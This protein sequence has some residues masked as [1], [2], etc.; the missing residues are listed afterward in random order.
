MYRVSKEIE[1]SAAHAIR[2]HLGG[3]ENMHGHNWRVRAT[4]EATKLD[5]MEMV[6]DYKELKGILKSIAE[7]LD[8]K[9]INEI[10]PFIKKNPTSE[11]I[12]RF[13][14]DELAGAINDGRRR[15]A[16][17]EVWETERNRAEYSE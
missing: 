11:N 7:K 2:G 17:V 16:L 1:F 6:I 4:V 13:F 15:V 10:E 3:C 14:F 5:D 8:H 9:Y 12:A